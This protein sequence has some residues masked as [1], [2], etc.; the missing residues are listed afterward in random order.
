MTEL[1]VGRLYVSFA[2][3]T[4]DF[5]ALF[6]QFRVLEKPSLERDLLIYGDAIGSFAY[7]DN[8]QIVFYYASNRH[9]TDGISK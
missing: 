4:I 2:W 6:I 9:E 1:H 3:N 5:R 8:V 7:S